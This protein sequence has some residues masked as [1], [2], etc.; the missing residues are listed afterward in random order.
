MKVHKTWYAVLAAAFVIR[1]L[2]GGGMSKLP[3]PN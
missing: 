3:R 1:F 2:G